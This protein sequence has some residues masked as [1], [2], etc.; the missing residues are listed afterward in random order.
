MRLALALVAAA[1]LLPATIG[2]AAILDAPSP[3]HS[4]VPRGIVLVGHDANGQADPF[5]AFQVVV[6][7]LNDRPIAYDQVEIN[8]TLCPDLRTAA[9]LPGYGIVCSEHIV[10]GLTDAMGVAR[11]NIAG[12]AI[13]IGAAPGPMAASCR[14]YCEHVLLRTVI[15]SAVDQNGFNG[16]EL[17]DF[18]ALLADL[19]SGYHARSDLDADGTLSANDVS[20]WLGAFFKGG[21]IAGAGSLPGGVCP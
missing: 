8:F 5:G 10:V 1:W 20:V 11:F 17:N 15:A 18:S 19:F 21:S 14:I 2:H 9:A 3:E 6:R 16:A 4:T 12:G 7:N 13:N